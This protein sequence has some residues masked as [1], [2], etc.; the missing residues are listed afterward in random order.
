[1]FEKVEINTID[2]VVLDRFEVRI[3]IPRSLR[4]FEVFDVGLKKKMSEAILSRDKVAYL[5]VIKELV[6]KMEAPNGQK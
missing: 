2:D 3:L 6:F 4:F 1:M 5:D